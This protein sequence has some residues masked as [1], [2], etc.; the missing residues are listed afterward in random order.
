MSINNKNRLDPA[1]DVGIEVYIAVVVFSAFALFFLPGFLCV[2][3]DRSFWHWAWWFSAPTILLIAFEALVFYFAGHKRGRLAAKLAVRPLKKHDFYSC[4][5]WYG[6]IMLSVPA[7]NI[8]WGKIISLL[9]IECAEKQEL[10][11]LL[12]TLS[13]GRFIFFLVV[14]AGLVPIAEEIIFR[15]SIYALW[16]KINPG[17]AFLGTAALFSAVHFFINGFAGLFLVG[18][19]FQ[20]AFLR[21]RNLLVSILLHGAFNATSVILTYCFE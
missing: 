6:V 18:I 11:E 13:F 9:G 3:A 12:Q 21:N 7:T 20:A 1:P 16:L 19:I 2:D 8:V 14:V 4:L 10:M 5:K 17:S 15:R